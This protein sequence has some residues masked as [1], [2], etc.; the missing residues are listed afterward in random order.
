MCLPACHSGKRAGANEN[1]DWHDTME[2]DV[3][4]GLAGVCGHPSMLVTFAANPSGA[5]LTFRNPSTPDCTS[6]PAGRAPLGGHRSPSGPE[7]IN[8]IDGISLLTQPQWNGISRP[9][10]P[11]FPSVWVRRR[12]MPSV[13]SI[14]TIDYCKVTR[15]QKV[16][17]VFAFNILV[18]SREKLKCS[19]FNYV[20]YELLCWLCC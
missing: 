13:L 11:A 17:I 19:F 16:K 10:T 2:M 12:I 9:V 3:W 20:L 15:D 8:F 4:S 6:D 5:L 7:N 14:G 1:I 18:E